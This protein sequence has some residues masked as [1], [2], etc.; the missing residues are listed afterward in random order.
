[1]EYSGHNNISQRISFTESISETEEE[2]PSARARR[3]WQWAIEQQLLLVRLE[4]ENQSVMRDTLRRYKLN[5]ADP[6][7]DNEVMGKVWLD[8]IEEGHPSTESLLA[9]VKM[10]T[11]Y[12]LVG[13]VCYKFT[14]VPPKLRERVWAL[15]MSHYQSLHPG[16][17]P[18]GSYKSSVSKQEYEQLYKQQTEYEPV[19]SVDIGRKYC[20]QYCLLLFYFRAHLS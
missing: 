18:S 14:G 12:C 2:D 1:M 20:V 8:L 4:K 10:G 11:V 3:R 13:C 17:V 6:A 7:V 19:I 9:A 16:E 15:L 5:Y